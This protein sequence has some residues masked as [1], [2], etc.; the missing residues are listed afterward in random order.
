MAKRRSTSNKPAS[1]L[2][3]ASNIP[4]GMTQIGGGYA[5]TWEPDEGDH[6]HGP[7]TSAV[8]TVEM[9]IGR[10]KQERRCVE[11]TDKNTGQRVTVWESAALVELFD[12]MVE[13]GEGVEV[14]IQ[15]DGLGKAK[16][17]GQNPPKL[18]TAALAA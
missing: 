13:A 17:A 16:K 8:K 2:P 10:K 11:I 3:Q 6:L 1:A 4:E 15:F 14:F 7:T 12:A 5:P 9:T 18:Y